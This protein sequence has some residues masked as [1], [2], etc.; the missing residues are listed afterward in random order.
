MKKSILSIYFILLI[1][2]C[3]NQEPQKTTPQKPLEVESLIGEEGETVILGYM[4]RANL[5]TPEFQAWF[6]P[7]YDNIK[8]PEGWAEEFKPLAKNLEF[9]LFLG[10]WCGDT[11]RELGGMFKLLDLMGVSQDKI[12][13]YSIS[14]AKD[15]PL[16][17]EKEYDILN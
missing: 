8:I 12:E 17:Y 4:N 5:N 2:G 10:T 15:S 11:Q 1:I 9:K 3:K 7:E 14:E 6:Q 13:M 16:G